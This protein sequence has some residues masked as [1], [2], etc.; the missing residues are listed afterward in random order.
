[1]TTQPTDARQLCGRKGDFKAGAG[2][3]KAGARD[4]KAGAQ[5]LGKH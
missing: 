5:G 3:F 2:D 4:F 1:M